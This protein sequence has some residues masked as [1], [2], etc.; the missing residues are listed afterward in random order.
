MT[1]VASS[2]KFWVTEVKRGKKKLCDHC[3]SGSLL[4][5]CKSSISHTRKFFLVQIC[6]HC[7]SIVEITEE[8]QTFKEKIVVI[9]K[10]M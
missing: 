3:G 4:K 8:H 5:F 6:D 9:C 7:G 1:T 10:K 2:L